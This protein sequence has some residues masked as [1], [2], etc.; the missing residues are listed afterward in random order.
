MKTKVANIVALCMLAGWLASPELAAADAIMGLMG[1]CPPGTREGVENH[2][3]VCVPTACGDFGCPPQSTCEDYNV[4]YEQREL[5]THR[6]DPYTG[7]AY[8]SMCEADGTCPSGGE[9][10]RAQRCEPSVSTPAWDAATRSWTGQPH[11]GV[12]LLDGTGLE[13]ALPAGY[14]QI[15]ITCGAACALVSLA[16]VVL[17][18]ILRLSRKKS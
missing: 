18:V 11:L 9:C 14:D 7:D 13:G 4:C 12:A 16:I 15:G 8:V 5:Q 17:A 6:G 3:A 2:A 1:P 10:R